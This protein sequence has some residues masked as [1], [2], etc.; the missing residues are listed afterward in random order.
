MNPHTSP[1]HPN[2]FVNF[3]VNYFDRSNSFVNFVVNYSDPD[4]DIDFDFLPRTQP[5]PGLK[6]RRRPRPAALAGVRIRPILECGASAPLWVPGRAARRPRNSPWQRFPACLAL[7]LPLPLALVLAVLTPLPSAAQALPPRLTPAGPLVAMLE[8]SDGWES[9]FDGNSLAGWEGDLAGY[10]AEDG[11]LV[12]T[13]QGG[14]LYTARTFSDFALAFRFKLTPGANNGLGIRS[15]R[16]GNPAYAG[17]ELQILDDDAPAYANLQPYQYHGSVYGIAP[18]RRG[19]LKP[20]GEWNL[21]YVLCIGPFVKVILND[22]T[23]V[24]VDLRA[25]QPADGQEH[26]GMTREDGRLV[27]FGHQAHVEFADLRIRDFTADAPAARTGDGPPPGFSALFNGRD[28][29][30]WQGLVRDPPTRARMSAEELRAAQQEADQ[31]MH[32]H[33]S[34]QDETLVFD[35]KGDNLCTVQDYADFELWVD[36]RIPAGADSGIYLRGSPQIQIWDPAHEPQWPQGAELGSGALW[37]NTAAGYRPYVRADHPIGEWNTFFIRMIGDRVT[38]ELNGLRVLD[39]V[40][41]ENYWERTKPIYP[42]GPIELQNHGSP[43][44]FR[45]LSVRRL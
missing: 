6:A 13:E 24:D 27:L 39:R 21:Q 10:R 5:E 41:M 40:I 43:L 38:V 19:F 36:W 32:A 37:N 35:G 14:S 17:M 16:D 22:E 29:A 18:A 26:P 15:P 7:P 9:L 8:Q 45:N 44:Y 4:P 30:G 2:C 42:A 11:V 33:W 3:V 28:L 1:Q 12:C 20:A 23:I 25:V 31:R 34:V